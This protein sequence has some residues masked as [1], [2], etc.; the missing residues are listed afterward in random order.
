[1]K[2]ILAIILSVTLLIAV[3]PLGVFNFTASA[4]TSEYYTYF[5]NEGQAIISECDKSISGDVVIPSK[6]GG[7]PV[8]AIHPQAFSNCTALT[9]L[10][11]PDGVT[12]IKEASFLNCTSLNSI[13]IPDTVTSIGEVAFLNCT[14]LKSVVIPNSVITIGSAA[15]SSCISL[16]KVTI[17]NGMTAINH[18]TF[19]NCSFLESIT[20]PN[21]VT[22][23]AESAF[24]GCNSLSTVNYSGTESEREKIENWYYNEALAN[25][26]WYYNISIGCAEHTYD[27]SCDTT[28]NICGDIRTDVNHIFDN[29]SDII[30]N[31]C[32]YHRYFSY[33]IN[34]GE[35]I[36]T[37]CY[38]LISGDIIIPSKYG[39]YPIKSIESNAFAS[40]NLLRSITIP[41]SV[42]NIGSGAFSGCSSLIDVTIPKNLISLGDDAFVSCTSLSSI[43][44]PESVIYIGSNAFSGCSSLK[45]VTIPRSLK[46]LENGAF[47]GCTGLTSLVI[48][49]GLLNIADSTFSGCSS[50][51]DIYYVGTEEQAEIMQI[52]TNNEFLVNAT[53]HYIKIGDLNGDCKVNLIDLVKLKKF[54]AK[55]EENLIYP[56]LDSDGDVTAKDLAALM[57]MILSTD[58][59]CTPKVRHFWRCIFLW[60]KKEQ[61]NKS[62]V[63]NSK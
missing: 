22:Y 3:C 53:W 58:L 51:V 37:D 40:C 32:G 43:T 48:S 10:A 21:S 16:T 36:I 63:Q 50:L 59:I 28:C 34:Y 19:E 29:A 33:T 54:F 60:Q 35:A 18:S 42:T 13:T 5:I 52:G 1:M 12:E 55:R 8:T 57:K 9:S 45:S 11:I 2:K 46:S 25:A 49:N 6:L 23:I 39:N 4:D 61:Y 20:L 24:S 47:S 26:T 56:D 44:F 38:D 27:D 14:S 15:F 30:C 7:Y 62:I 41:D 17:S 31:N